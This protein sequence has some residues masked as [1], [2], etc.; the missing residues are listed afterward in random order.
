MVNGGS[1]IMGMKYGGRAVG[2]HPYSWEG[3]C[4]LLW[5]QV[6]ILF[7]KAL[8]SSMS[9]EVVL[10]LVCYL[11]TW[12]WP[13][14][15]VWCSIDWLVINDCCSVWLNLSLIYL[16]WNTFIYLN[17]DCLLQISHISSSRMWVRIVRHEAQWQ[18]SWKMQITIS[19]LTEIDD[20]LSL[21]RT[22]YHTYQLY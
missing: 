10:I 13:E 9:L 22:R 1:L 19:P 5:L 15:F 20:S 16:N 7:I 2:H 11:M 3:V 18:P 14:W 12:R 6:E 4:C 21:S 17:V 8:S